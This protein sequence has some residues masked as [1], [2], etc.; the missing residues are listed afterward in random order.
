VN[1]T[2][3]LHCIS[4]GKLH[5]NSF[6]ENN[7]V[8]EIL[9]KSSNCRPFRSGGRFHDANLLHLAP[10]GWTKLLICSFVIQSGDKFVLVVG[11]Y[12]FAQ[13]ADI[14]QVGKINQNALLYLFMHK[15]ATALQ[16]EQN[17]L[18]PRFQRPSLQ[19]WMFT[20]SLVVSPSIVFF[21]GKS[22]SLESTDKKRFDERHRLSNIWRK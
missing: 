16:G 14:K 20:V 5:D 3:E 19:S 17:V 13:T 10:Q 15:N 1:E 9:T 11:N 12:I 6:G 21:V 22:S 2:A 4:G 18:F 8:L 7:D